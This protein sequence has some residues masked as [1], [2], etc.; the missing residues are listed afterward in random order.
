MLNILYDKLIRF[1]NNTKWLIIW[2][3]SH[4][5]KLTFYFP[6]RPLTHPLTL[7]NISCDASKSMIHHYATIALSRTA[8]SPP[9]MI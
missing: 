5:A 9:N 4:Y 3:H 1:G 2:Y 8:H 7:T 6:F